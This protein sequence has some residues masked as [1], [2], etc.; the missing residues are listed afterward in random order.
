MEGLRATHGWRP[1]HDATASA[2]HRE[3]VATALQTLPGVGRKVADCVALFSL[4]QPGA[5]PVDT[6]VWAIACRFLDPD[7]RNVR[8]ITPAVHA[9]VGDLFRDKYGPHAGWAHCL[10]F[11]AELNAFSALIPP[12]IKLEQV[13]AV[14]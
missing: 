10:L 2:A 5:V 4:D 7:L 9:R 6:H 11:A 8:S 13:K 1:D 14:L 12:E 3:A